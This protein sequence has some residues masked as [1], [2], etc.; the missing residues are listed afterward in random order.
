MFKQNEATEEITKIYSRFY[1]TLSVQTRTKQV[2]TKG[3][4]SM[5]TL[6][7]REILQEDLDKISH[8]SNANN[9][10]SIILFNEF[11][12]HVI[13]NLTNMPK[14]T[15]YKKL[16]ERFDEVTREYKPPYHNIRA[17]TIKLIT[18]LTN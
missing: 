7:L 18:R 4:E 14:R 10:R 3:N 15:E 2:I 9:L 16:I 5:I 17:N 8:E 6:S 1:A 12:T 13:S 11:D